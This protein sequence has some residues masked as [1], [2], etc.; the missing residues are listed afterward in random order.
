MERNKQNDRK[1]QAEKSPQQNQKEQKTLK[2]KAEY[3]QK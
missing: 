1:Q 3:Q 2:N